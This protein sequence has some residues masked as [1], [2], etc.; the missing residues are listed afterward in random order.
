MKRVCVYCGSSSGSRPEYRAAAEHLGRRL[1]ERGLGLV[2][3]GGNVGLMGVLANAVMAAGGEVVGVIPEALLAWE[4]GHRDV[5]RLH[6]VGSMHERKAL[7]ADLSDAFMALPGGIGTMEEM[8]ETWTW[9]QLG[10]HRKPLALLD[11]AGYFGKLTGF[12]DLMVEEGFLQAQHREFIHI[13]TDADAVL[14][15]FATYVPPQVERRVE[16]DQT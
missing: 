3:G 10:Y 12:I 8:F 1:A 11:V 13:G 14:D 2:Y 9:G 4:V 5:T 6:V 7:M 15:H 16:R